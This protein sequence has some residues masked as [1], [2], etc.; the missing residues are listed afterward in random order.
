MPTV[1]EVLDA[2]EIIAP[3]R[4]AL[5]FDKVGLQVGDRHGDITKA[6]VSLDRSLAAVD[7]AIKEGAQLLLSHH[8]LIFEPLASAT[9]DTHTGRTVLRLIENRIAFIAAHTNWDAAPGGINDT[10]ASRLGLEDVKPFGMAA[11]SKQLKLVFFA[12]HGSEQKLIDAASEAGAGVIGLYTRC[13]FIG[14]GTG[15]F[16]AAPG[17]DPTI[18]EVGS[19][20]EVS[21]SK[22]EMVLPESTRNAVERALRAAHPYEEPAFD[23]VQL[24]DWKEHALGRVGTLPQ[25]VPFADFVHAVDAALD[26]RSWG[27]GRERTVRKVAVVGGAADTEWMNAQRAGA[28]VLVTGEVKQHFAVEAAESGMCIVAA[29]HYATEHPGCIALAERMSQEVEG[30]EWKIFEPSPGIAGR[31]L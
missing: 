1:Q 25:A 16:Y 4:F 19:V 9:S 30:V 5:S 31:P 18:G 29:G 28:D 17:T 14:N 11:T 8:P 26:T 20:E 13:A 6:V 7:Y 3:K 24:V 27:F 22:I 10:L 12:P 2:L 23:F 21:E 15:T